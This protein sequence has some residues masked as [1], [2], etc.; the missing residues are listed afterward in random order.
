MT[1]REIINQVGAPA[2]FEGIAEEA[3]ELAKAALKTARV[4]RKENPT[5]VT[6]D[7]AAR[8]VVVEYSDLRIYIDILRIFVDGEVYDEKKQRFVERLKEGS[9]K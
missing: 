2:L 8:E 3:A 1:D 4:M 6:L 9:E 7:D 5:P